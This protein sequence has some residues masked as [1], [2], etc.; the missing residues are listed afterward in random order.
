MGLFIE[1]TCHVECKSIHIFIFLVSVPPTK[2]KILTQSGNALEDERYNEGTDLKLSCF[3]SG[4][5]IL[6]ID[7]IN[8]PQK[9]VLLKL[10]YRPGLC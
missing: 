2:V 7:Q 5:N 3:V 8:F 4:G 9:E 6:Y 1:L 10:I